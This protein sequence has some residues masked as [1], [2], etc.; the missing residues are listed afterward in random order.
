[1]NKLTYLMSI[2]AL[3]CTTSIQTTYAADPMV[4]AAG[5]EGKG[6]DAKAKEIAERMKQR[7]IPTTVSNLN[8]S[9]EISLAVC[10]GQAQIGIMQIDAVYA[11]AQDGCTLKA[12][13]IYGTEIGVILFPPNSDYD[14]LSD[15]TEADTIAVDT[16]GSGTALFWSTLVK[17]ENSKD[18]SG[19]EWA[20]TKVSYDPI[21]LANTNA[22]MGSIKALLLVRKPDSPD[23]SSLLELGWTLGYLYDKDINDLTFNGGSLYESAKV[24]VTYSDTYVKNW[25]YAVR[26]FIVVNSK[27]ANG[28]RQV[29][30]TI[31]ASL[32]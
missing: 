3:L 10:S 9:D 18:G 7:G 21:E 25:T 5:K 2:A 1:M 30:Q 26:S 4:I 16:I 27:V 8:G 17:I 28:D 31:A 15:L 24:K 19:D 11:R 20:K 22:S 23:I 6:Y 13:G 29:F 14:E 32:Q 12:V